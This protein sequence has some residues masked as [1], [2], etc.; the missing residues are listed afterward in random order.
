M[1]QLYSKY[2]KT[3]L[4]SRVYRNVIHQTIA[5]LWC[6]LGRYDLITRSFHCRIVFPRRMYHSKDVRVAKM[7]YCQGRRKKRSRTDRTKLSTH[8]ISDPNH[9]QMIRLCNRILIRL[10]TNASVFFSL[11]NNI[12]FWTNWFIDVRVMHIPNL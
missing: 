9:I 7:N 1:P 12:F 3:S 8:R 4:M 11:S 2:N 6:T 10:T 5:I